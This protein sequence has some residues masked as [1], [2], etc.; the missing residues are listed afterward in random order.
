M[1]TKPCGAIPQGLEEY[2]ETAQGGKPMANKSFRDGPDNAP[3]SDAG[4]TAHPL[5]AFRTAVGSFIDDFFTSFDLLPLIVFED[6]GAYMP[7]ISVS[8]DR[9]AVTVTAVLPGLEA[10]DIEVTL[11]GGTLVIQGQGKRSGMLP[12]A[13]FTPVDFP[14][15]PFRKMIP[16]PY[17][18]D[19]QKARATFRDRVLRVVIPL[20]AGNTSAKFRIPIRG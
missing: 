5:D 16:L 13:A 15:P 19:A 3:S 20:T 7:R 2:A 6:A 18:I 1:K 14:A 4:A 11:G 10:S 17:S 8:H 12:G 9:H